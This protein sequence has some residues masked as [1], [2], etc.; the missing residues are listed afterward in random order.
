MKGEHLP[1]GMA[2]LGIAELS[3]PA[4]GREHKQ[5]GF[6][7]V[8][9]LLVTAV[10]GLMLVMTIP[11]VSSLGRAGNLEKTAADI[12]GFLELARSHARA[13]NATVDVGFRSTDEGISL[14]AVTGREGTNFSAISRIRRFPN[15]RI[16]SVGGGSRPPADFQMGVRTGDEIGGFQA[17]GES[18]EHVVQFNSR[19]EARSLSNSLSRVMEIGIMPREPN[20]ANYGVVQ[21]AGLSGDVSIY[22]P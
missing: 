9:L 16:A 4:F 3:G 10:T 5:A 20:Q 15:V 2:G 7:L 21:V 1:K 8:E 13:N 12:A 17:G 19:G 22:R 18:F 14:V 6:S 11:A